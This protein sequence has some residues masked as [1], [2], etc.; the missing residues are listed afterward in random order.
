MTMRSPI[1]F[2]TIV[3]FSLTLSAGAYAQAVGAGRA[4]AN[5]GSYTVTG[6]VTLPDGRPAVGAQVDVTCDFTTASGN[7]DSDGVYRLTGIPAGNCK[8]STKVAGF[9][10]ISENRTINR[11][12][13]YGQS[14]Y[15]PIF[16]RSDPYGSNPLYAGV[17]KPALDKYKKAME[18]IDKGD[19]DGALSSLDQAISAHAAFAAAWYQ[20]GQIYLKRNESDKAVA[21]FVK[22][23]EIKADYL[24]AKYG[25]GVAQFQKKDYAVSEAVFRDVLQKVDMPEAHL[26]LGISLFYLKKSDAAETE[27]KSAA[28][29]KAGDKLALAHLYLGQIYIQRKNN[30]DAIIELQKYVELVPK[31]P[32]ADRVKATIAD[33]KKQS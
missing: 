21:A 14:I 6:K 4:G 11:D 20:K 25:F 32:N 17:P 3:G 19:A 12:T 1:R 27:L 30:A 8:I 15:V 24:E 5:S 26:N 13:P 22:A 9:E 18:K 29:S 23:I 16:L 2:L 10:P 7:T 33:L 28:A 31:A